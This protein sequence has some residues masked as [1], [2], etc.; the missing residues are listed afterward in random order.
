MEGKNIRYDDINLACIKK[1][2]EFR[3]S[4]RVLESDGLSS[5]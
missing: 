2:I 4:G 1:I 3:F 5:K